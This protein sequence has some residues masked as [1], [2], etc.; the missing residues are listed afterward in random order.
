[1]LVAGHL[2]GAQCL[3]HNLLQMKVKLK[4]LLVA[5][6]ALHQSW[7]GLDG[8]AKQPPPVGDVGL[9]S[10]VQVQVEFAL[11]LIDIRQRNPECYLIGGNNNHHIS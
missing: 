5:F 2:L 9:A 7:K 6:V 4:V 10:V 8:T 3:P 1:M 11:L